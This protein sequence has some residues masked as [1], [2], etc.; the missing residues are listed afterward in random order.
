MNTYIINQKHNL[1]NNT[2]DEDILISATN[3]ADFVLELN[4][5]SILKKP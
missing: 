3:K 5:A 1:V 4:S 2:S